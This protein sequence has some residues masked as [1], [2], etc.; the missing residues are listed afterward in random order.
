[1]YYY[2]YQCPCSLVYILGV[3]FDS[4]ILSYTLMDTTTVEGKTNVKLPRTLL[5]SA[6]WR[7]GQ[8]RKED[9]KTD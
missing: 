3:S 7:R 4:R 5:V 1:M 9:T 2:H 8:E 6:I